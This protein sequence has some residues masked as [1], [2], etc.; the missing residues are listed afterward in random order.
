[1][2]PESG[3]SDTAR[4]LTLAVG[5]DDGVFA[6]WNGTRMHY[7]THVRAD[8]RTK[9]HDVYTDGMIEPHIEAWSHDGWPSPM[10]V[11]M[12]GMTQTG[13]SSRWRAK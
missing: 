8:R 4:S 3:R 1:M 9:D 13:T 7:R 5:A 12:Q 2:A 10:R 11:S 6:W